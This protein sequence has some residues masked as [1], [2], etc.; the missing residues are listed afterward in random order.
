MKQRGSQCGGVHAHVREDVRYFEK[1]RKVRI[2]G[3]A[4]LVAVA[5]RCNFIRAMDQPGIIGWAIFL[6]LIQQLMEPRIEL[7]LAAIAVK[8]KR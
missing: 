3:T 1:V 2:A 4:K 7:A 5:L 6:E 8:L